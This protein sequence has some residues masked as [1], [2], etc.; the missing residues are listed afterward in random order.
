M[1][2]AELDAN[3]EFYLSSTEQTT[4]RANPKSKVGE[5][6]KISGNIQHQSKV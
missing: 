6:A 4:R 1:N 3:A 5:K 2:H